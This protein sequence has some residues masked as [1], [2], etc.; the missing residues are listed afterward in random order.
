MWLAQSGHGAERA[1]DSIFG[2]GV[3]GGLLSCWGEDSCFPGS[4]MGSPGSFEQRSIV[5]YSLL[6]CNSLQHFLAL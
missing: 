5:T 3:P 4:G 2:G 1:G 6:L